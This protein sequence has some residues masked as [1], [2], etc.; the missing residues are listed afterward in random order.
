MRNFLL[1]LMLLCFLCGLAITVSSCG[2]EPRLT[3]EQL[4]AS[5]SPVADCDLYTMLEV[6][7]GI[8][9]V[10]GEE[11]VR[12]CN[13]MSTKFGIKPTTR[14]LRANAKVA[15]IISLA[16][17]SAGRGNDVVTLGETL[18]SIVLK[19]GQTDPAA[20]FNTFELVLKSYQATNGDI[21]PE[22][23]LY[24]LASAGPMAK[25]LSDDGLINM[26]AVLHTQK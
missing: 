25:T 7:D 2:D 10:S 5:V 22:D 16:E 21:H 8:P 3:P 9:T 20:M 4:D 18:N 19:R 1:R 6:M 15:S 23:I 13:D 17:G 24:F 12:L 11:A 26:I 14:A